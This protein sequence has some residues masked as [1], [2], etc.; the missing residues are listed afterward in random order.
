MGEWRAD[1]SKKS[2]RYVWQE[3]R[4]QN[5]ETWQDFAR[6]AKPFPAFAALRFEK[7]GKEIHCWR[8]AAE[9]GGASYWM[10]CLRF[11]D[12]GWGYWTVYYRSDERRWRTTPIKEFPL[13]RAVAAAAE[14]Y[15]D[16]LTGK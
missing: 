11:V 16:K 1:Q 14:F 2:R 10:S 6:R 9:S 12:D 13:G 8:E 4:G 3:T 5:D 15:R 7:L